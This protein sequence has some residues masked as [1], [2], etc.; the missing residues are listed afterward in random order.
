VRKK[1]KVVAEINADGHVTRTENK[2]GISSVSLG[3]P[4]LNN[5]GLSTACTHVALQIAQGLAFEK[6]WKSKFYP[7]PCKERREVILVLY[8]LN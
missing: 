8:R 3:R 5:S 4:C 2:V 7:S 1:H 6:F